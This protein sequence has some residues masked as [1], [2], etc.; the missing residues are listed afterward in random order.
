LFTK[1]FAILKLIPALWNTVKQ[2]GNTI[3]ILWQRFT[4]QRRRKKVKEAVKD[5]KELKDTSKLENLFRNDD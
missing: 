1:I 2:I 5:A 4:V 3:S